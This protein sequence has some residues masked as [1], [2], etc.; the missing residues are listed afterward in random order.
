MP[1]HSVIVINAEGIVVFSKYF[2]LG[3]SHGGG[4][5]HQEQLLFE[6][7]LFQSTSRI[8]TAKAITSIIQTVTLGDVHVVFQ[9]LGELLVFVC[10]VDDMDEVICE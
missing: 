8:W 9:R 3:S 10:G 5:P 4:K 6:Q 2:M 1:V 7:Q